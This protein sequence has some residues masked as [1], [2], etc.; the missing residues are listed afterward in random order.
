MTA[1][2]TINQNQFALLKK[3]LEQSSSSSRPESA[4]ELLLRLNISLSESSGSLPFLSNFHLLILVFIHLNYALDYSFD[5]QQLKNEFEP[6][7][8]A[9]LPDYPTQNLIQNYDREIQELIAARIMIVSTESGMKSKLNVFLPLSPQ[10][11]FSLPN[12]LEISD[13][14]FPPVDSNL[15][16]QS[17]LNSPS[18]FLRNDSSAQQFLGGSPVDFYRSQPFQGE[19]TPIDQADSFYPFQVAPPGVGEFRHLTIPHIQPVKGMVVTTFVPDKTK[20]P[21]SKKRKNNP[22]T[23]VFYPAY[24]HLSK[25]RIIGHHETLKTE[26]AEQVSKYKL[27]QQQSLDEIKIAKRELAEAREQ[28]EKANVENKTLKNQVMTS[29][30]SKVGTDNKVI[31]DELNLYKR[32]FLQAHALGQAQVV[33]INNLQSNVTILTKENDTLKEESDTVEEYKEVA[34]QKTIDFHNL[35]KTNI[36][37]AFKVTA[38]TAKYKTLKREFKDQLAQLTTDERGSVDSDVI[39]IKPESDG[40]QENPESESLSQSEPGKS[41]ILDGRHFMLTQAKITAEKLF[42]ENQRLLAE[43]ELFKYQ[44][45]KIQQEIDK[46]TVLIKAQFVKLQQEVDNAAIRLLESVENK[47]S[48]FEHQL[49]YVKHQIQILFAQLQKAKDINH[50]LEKYYVSQFQPLK[51][52]KQTLADQLKKSKDANHDMEQQYIL[53]I[54]QLNN[55]KESM[56]CS[57]DK[58]INDT[59]SLLSRSL[60]LL[61]HYRDTLEKRDNLID[62]LPMH[63]TLPTS[64]TSGITP[65]LDLIANYQSQIQTLTTQLDEAKAK[66]EIYRPGPTAAGDELSVEEKVEVETEETQEATRAIAARTRQRL[67]FLNMCTLTPNE[68]K[69]LIAEIKETSNHRSRLG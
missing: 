43:L 16:F 30:V 44:E 62:G 22:T 20:A 6:F 56:Q 54:Q 48:Q 47:F 55:E 52:G 7:L 24:S 57:K 27:L 60:T 33:L 67:S 15:L 3:I 17:G 1:L 49:E 21:P 53:Q 29:V 50:N 40:K 64:Q 69:A 11:M 39:F 66:L 37:L 25:S 2:A 32:S 31:Q 12:A 41:S 5:Y 8:L 58:E 28:L 36:T 18:N 45:G 42:Q 65:K 63:M 26:Y 10:P 59:R 68:S 4:T 35:L 38:L 9:H 19:A 61:H 34:S 51:D 14:M 46:N 13:D 23:D